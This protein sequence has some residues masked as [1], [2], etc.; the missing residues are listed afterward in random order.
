MRRSTLLAFNA[1]H[2][3][4]GRRGGFFEVTKEAAL[5]PQLAAAELGKKEFIFDVQ[6]HL[7]NPAGAYVAHWRKAM[8]LTYFAGRYYDPAIGRFASVDQWASS[9]RIHEFQPLPVRQR[10]PQ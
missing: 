7:V 3:R 10:Q 9:N 5:E 4:D 2:A 1:A 6:G 8:R